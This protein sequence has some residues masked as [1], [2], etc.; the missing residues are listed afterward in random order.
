MSRDAN[1]VW[2]SYARRVT[3]LKNK[4]AATK[5]PVKKSLKPLSAKSAAAIAAERP[6]LP[7]AAPP[8]DLAAPVVFDRATERRFRAG[9][10]RLDAKL[11]LH[12]LRQDQAY[13]ALARFLAA[14]VA[15]GSRKLLIITGQGRGQ[16]GVLRGQLPGWLETLNAARQIIDLRP[17]APK[18]GGAGAFYVWLKRPG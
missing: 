1:G 5:P 9:A 13:A 4:P 11:D 3:P 2:D 16:A 6:V 10:I 17:A 8:V 18:H 12:G 7:R 14:Q 15:A